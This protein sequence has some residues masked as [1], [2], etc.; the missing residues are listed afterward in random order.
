MSDETKIAL[1]TA[2]RAHIAD[3]HEGSLAA[4]WVLIAERVPLDGDDDYTHVVDIV[5]DGQSSVTTIGLAHYV[6]QMRST[7]GRA[8]DD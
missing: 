5:A 2:I 7:V 6:A 3:E 8:A 4:S 1:D